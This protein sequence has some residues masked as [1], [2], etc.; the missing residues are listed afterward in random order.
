MQHDVMIKVTSTAICG[1]DLHLYINAMPGK[2]LCSFLHHA[3]IARG[4][5]LAAKIIDLVWLDCI[6]VHRFRC[7]VWLNPAYPE[8]ID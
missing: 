3:F 7:V 4:T 6:Q 8:P 1:S 5:S 2:Q